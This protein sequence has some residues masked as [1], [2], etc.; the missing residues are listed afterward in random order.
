MG[1]ERTPE[2]ATFPRFG[3]AGGGRYLLCIQLQR[4]IARDQTKVVTA[5]NKCVERGKE[6]PREGIGAHMYVSRPSCSSTPALLHSIRTPPSDRSC[7]RLCDSLIQGRV[8][9]CS[10]DAPRQSHHS[11][12]RGWLPALWPAFLSTVD[13]S[14]SLP[15]LVQTQQTTRELTH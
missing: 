4:L 14:P 2:A 3:D 11:L 7:P 1:C 8:L 13:P 15:L 5:V 10:R 6:A 9:R 12:S